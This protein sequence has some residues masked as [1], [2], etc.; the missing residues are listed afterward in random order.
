MIGLLFNLFI[1][2]IKSRIKQRTFRR[3]YFE[4]KYDYT[5]QENYHGN[6]RFEV[7]LRDAEDG[8]EI[9]NTL[10]IAECSF[11]LGIEQVKCVQLL[12]LIPRYI[13]IYNDPITQLQAN[14][15]WKRQVQK[16]W[17]LF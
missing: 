8:L 10:Q 11:G 16:D 9:M 3:I 17:N 13:H 12:M 14:Y 4:Q 2:L 6:W 15:L 5:E 1:H 7:D